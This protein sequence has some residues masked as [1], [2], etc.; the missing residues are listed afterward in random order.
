MVNPPRPPWT[1]ALIGG[2]AS[3]K[4]TAA[5]LFAAAGATVVD[6][7][8]LAHQLT[9]AG[10]AALP[11]LVQ[12]FGAGV[13]DAGGALDRA[14]MRARA[15]ANPSVRQQLE[16]VMHPLIRAA[17]EQSLQAASGA[18]A[19]LAVPLFVES[20]SWQQR[21]QRVLAMDCAEEVQ[22]ARALRRPGVSAA[23]VDA[24]LA[25]Q[26]TRAARLA[27]ADDVI[28]NSVDTLDLQP[29][30]AVLHQRYL[31][32][33]AEWAHHSPHPLHAVAQGGTQE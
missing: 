11:A 4:S 8:G 27:V 21:V 18:Y 32:L 1:V 30:I 20:G 31:V 2:I 29:L 17:A 16:A 23:Q 25:V 15:F 24:I 26:A 3:G 12:V 33:A 28:E 19:V 9:A 14:A 6:L 5:A 22:R 13:L 7:D 10:G